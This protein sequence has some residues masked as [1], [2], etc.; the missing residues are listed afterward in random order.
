MSIAHFPSMVSGKSK[1]YFGSGL[2]GGNRFTQMKGVENKIGAFHR[3][4]MAEQPPRIDNKVAD[5]RADELYYLNG[6]VMG[7]IPK[8]QPQGSFSRPLNMTGNTAHGVGL[9][10]AGGTMRTQA[11]QRYGIALLRR[12]AQQL[13][14]L[15]AMASGAPIAPADPQAMREEIEQVP[16]TP[17]EEKKMNVLE[18]DISELADK[19]RGRDWEE[20]RAKNIANLYNKLS[21]NLGQK[22]S[23]GK[24]KSLNQVVGGAVEEIRNDTEFLAM[25]DRAEQSS[26]DQRKALK[27]LK[28]LSAPMAK[29]ARITKCLED[30]LNLQPR[31]R[32]MA[33]RACRDGAQRLPGR[34]PER[35]MGE[36]INLDTPSTSSAPSF[37]SSGYFDDPQTR[38]RGRNRTREVFE[39][40]AQ[41]SRTM[42]AADFPAEDER[43]MV[44]VDMGRDAQD[45]SGQRYF[46]DMVELGEEEEDLG[47]TRGRVPPSLRDF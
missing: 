20:L 44:A 40:Q 3:E 35:A 21:G 31:E 29:L 37:A 9:S 17:E 5:D 30:T 2:S 22:L 47:G 11:G 25:V 38:R 16:E 46:D 6:G 24:V 4:Q 42:G 32:A 12:R 41:H 45:R 28:S 26:A 1:S 13:N 10:G 15:E 19:V 34:L 23:A 14:Q 18:T 39:P 27:R 7:V 36:V 8:P 33:M 43:E